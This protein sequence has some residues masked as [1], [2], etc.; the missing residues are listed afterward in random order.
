MDSTNPGQAL[1]F[2]AMEDAARA[3]RVQLQRVDIRT[4]TD[5]E[6][7]FVTT[8]RQRAEALVV[9]PLHTTPRELQRIEEFVI[10]NR[11]PTATIY[12]AYVKAG[13]LLFYGP[14]IP[15]VCQRAANYI[16]KVLKGG[17]PADLPVEQLTKFDLVINL[18]T[19]KALGPHDPAVDAG[20]GGSGD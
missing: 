15:D 19:A 10:K 17:R 14:N 9:Y 13:L 18:K 3:L 20:A 8:L 4:A 7:A 16:D 12:S 5:L 6:G 2:S 11:L 1:P